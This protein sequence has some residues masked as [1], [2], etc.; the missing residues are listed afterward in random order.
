MKVPA[1][2][3]L[4][5]RK[6]DL[7]DL[8]PDD[9]IVDPYPLYEQLRETA[10]VHFASEMG[11]SPGE[12]LVT[13]YEDVTE[14]LSNTAKYKPAEGGDSI[15]GATFLC[16]GAEHKRLR[17]IQLKSLQ[18]KVLLARVEP[19]VQEH[20][21]K[22]LDPVRGIG[23]LEL[24]KSILRPL[25][26]T[27]VGHLYGDH[28]IPLHTMARWADGMWEAF[29]L[30]LDDDP[31]RLAL[32]DQTYSEVMA[33]YPGLLDSLTR[34]QV[35]AYYLA[36]LEF[37]DLTRDEVLAQLPF[38]MMNHREPGDVL[39][40]MMWALL[41]HPEEGKRCTADFR[42]MRSAVDETL[43]WDGLLGATTRV[44]KCP[45]ELSGT[46]VPE[47][48]LIATMLAASNHDERRFTA[49]TEF[50]VDRNEGL[51]NSFGTGPHT[52]LGAPIIRAFCSVGAKILFEKLP[53]LRLAENAPG[54]REDGCMQRRLSSLW[55]E[56]DV[57]Q[58]AAA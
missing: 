32:L 50:R 29:E 25:S 28:E 17:E 47:G 3:V 13:R 5:D 7:N 22:L 11:P 26:I 52:C 37:S 40:L 51:H 8:V 27:V 41:S 6:R 45:V 48:A 16:E 38:A 9:F 15:K 1:D 4:A 42:L 14:V 56:W 53:N 33:V 58:P 10:P 57:P 12:W 43:R 46:S 19:L 49:P 55:V 34:D 54:V 21:D 20:I 24:V 31:E 36:N 39:S 23:R 30:A 18:N 44:T 35:P 2:Q